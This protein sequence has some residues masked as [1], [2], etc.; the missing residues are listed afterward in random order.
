LSP[1]DVPTIS[2]MPQFRNL[3]VNC[4]HGSMGLTFSLGSARVMRG[5]IDGTI[6]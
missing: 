4:G 6:D 3:Y 5:I 1:D 2:R